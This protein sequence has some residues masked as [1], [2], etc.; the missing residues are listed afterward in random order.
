MP[1]PRPRLKTNRP[2]SP[3]RARA[4]HG[5]RPPA[6]R[7]SP[8]PR[9]P[10]TPHSSSCRCRHKRRPWRVALPPHIL[11]TPRST[12]GRR[13]CA[14][15]STRGTG[16]PGFVGRRQGPAYSHIITHATGST[17]APKYDI[18]RSGLH[19]ELRWGRAQVGDVASRLNIPPRTR[20]AEPPASP[21]CSASSGRPSNHT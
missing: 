16:W 2:L 12:P 11:P 19:Q 9:P 10:T 5:P 20:T 8:V 14:W 4:L 3:P 1:P 18:C 21:A 6:R 13:G 17:R 7:S 15:R